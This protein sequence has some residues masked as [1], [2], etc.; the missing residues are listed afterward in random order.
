MPFQNLT[1]TLHTVVEKIEDYGISTTEYYKLRLFKTSMK[2][3]ISL[4]NLL[5][6]GSLFLFVMLFISIGAALWLGTIL[7]SAFAGFFIIGGIYVVILIFMFALGRKII[8]RR[9]LYSFS[10]LMYDEDDP[11]PRYMAEREIAD[12]KNELRKDVLQKEKFSK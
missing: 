12:L 5:V 10:G 3:A 9:M 2:V 11:D 1:D 4:V 8:E 6:Y 7:D